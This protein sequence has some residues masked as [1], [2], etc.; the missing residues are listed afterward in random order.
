MADA[1]NLRWKLDQ[2]YVFQNKSED[3]YT[4]LTIEPNAQ[5]LAAAPPS[6]ALPTHL[7]VVVDVSA[8]MDYLMR[9]DPNAKVLGSVLT[10]GQ[11]SKSVE[12]SVPSRREVAMMVVQRLFERMGAGDSLSLVAFDDQAH[13][14]ANR[15]PA[16]SKT[17]LEM[18]IH[19]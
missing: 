8:S 17:P 12:S 14:L 3:I 10:E 18:A 7:I 9:Y 13:I 4:L 16:T 15:L 2:P 11:S 1:F 5:A 19:R 6:P